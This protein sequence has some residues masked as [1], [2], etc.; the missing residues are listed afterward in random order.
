MVQEDESPD[1]ASEENKQ[2]DDEAAEHAARLGGRPAAAETRE[3]GQEPSHDEADD[4]EQEVG[5]VFGV[6]L[7]QAG[8]DIAAN[9]GVSSIHKHV[10]SAAK[11]SEESELKR[12]RNEENF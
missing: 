3:G 7:V 11:Q 12:F 4:D 5:R 10:D 6:S 8:L 2:D 9:E 1:R